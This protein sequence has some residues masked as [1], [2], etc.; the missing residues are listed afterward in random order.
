MES[1]R[2]LKVLC[3][4]QWAKD[5]EKAT[6]LTWRRGCFSR[7]FQQ[8]EISLL[9]S[10]SRV[11][12]ML[13][14]LELVKSICLQKCF[15]KKSLVTYPLRDLQSAHHH[16]NAYISYV[17]CQSLDATSHPVAARGHCR[18]K[19]LQHSLRK[20]LPQQTEARTSF[21]VT[22]LRCPAFS[23]LETLP[24][25]VEMLESL[26]SLLPF[27]LSSLPDSALTWCQFYLSFGWNPWR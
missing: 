21:T 17:C 11:L 13:L 6:W 24:I 26:C 25:L 3:T 12:L 14:R 2:I 7:S 16:I 1:W 15:R 8:S 20:I 5:E 27:T 22:F 19:R 9:D 10:E 4:G 23:A 18:P